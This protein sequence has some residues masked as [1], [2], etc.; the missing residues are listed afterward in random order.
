MRWRKRRAIMS[1]GYPSARE[2]AAGLG[3][4]KSGQG[5]T[6]KCPAR[7]DRTPS[8]SICE[9][10]GKVLVKCWTGCSQQEVIAALRARGLWGGRDRQVRSPP[11]RLSLCTRQR[12]PSAAQRFERALRPWQDAKPLQGTSAENYLTSRGLTLPG[13]HSLRFHPSLWHWQ[14]ESDW[15][16]IVAL[17]TNAASGQPLGTHQTFL[18]RDCRR[19]APVDKPR[20]FAGSIGGG[21]VWFGETGPDDEL[22]VAEGVESTLSGMRLYGAT[23]RRRRARGRLRPEGDCDRRRQRHAGQ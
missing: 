23:E 7:D 19:K 10:G 1:S 16:A 3:G 22:I 21:G 9:R 15:P 5:W 12:E 2:I 13:V 18:A 8:L 17:V 20:L 11:E 4:R 6:A 14:S